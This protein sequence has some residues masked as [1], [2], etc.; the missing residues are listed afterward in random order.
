MSE[1][2]VSRILSH[3]MAM[4]GSDG[5]A[6]DVRPHPRLWGTFPRVLGHYVREKKLFSLETAIY[7]M[8]GLS[9]RRFGLTDRGTL[10]P[11]HH[12]DI[13]IFDPDHVNAN[14]SYRQPTEVSSG[15]DAVFVNGQLACRDGN[16]VCTNAGQ[17]LRRQGAVP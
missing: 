10:A 11:G 17:V 1:D 13:V 12:A 3:P 9:A 5:L 15:I 6:H 16:T 14:A 7:K 4:V 2:D 8:T